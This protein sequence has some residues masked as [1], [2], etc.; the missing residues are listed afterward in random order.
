MGP[1]RV[2]GAPP[3]ARLVAFVRESNR[4]EGIERDPTPAEIEAHETLLAERDI[5][6]E[7]LARF[8]TDVA[9]RPLRDTVGMDVRVG[10]H[11]PPPGGPLIRESLEQLV[12]MVRE[13]GYSP[14]EIHVKYETLH[15]FL[16]ANGRSGRALWAWQMRRDGQDPFLLPFLH[17][18]YYQA[19]NAA[20]DG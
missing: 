6:V 15:P 1:I 9:A 5:T 8:V 4:I 19:L 2:E 13:G 14:Y 12:D 7:T 17:R 16:D 3:D 18:F 20:G 11:F 10:S